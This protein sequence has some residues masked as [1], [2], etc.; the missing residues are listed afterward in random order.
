MPGSYK[1]KSE[2]LIFGKNSYLLLAWSVVLRFTVASGVSGMSQ[3]S[4][5][6]AKIRGGKNSYTFLGSV[7]GA[8]E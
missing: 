8:S 5:L 4:H 1:Q 3:A 2:K 6:V 7:A